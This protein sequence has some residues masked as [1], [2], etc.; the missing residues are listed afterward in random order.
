MRTSKKGIDLIKQFE[1]CKLYAYRDAVGKPTIGYGH[2]LGVKMGTTITQAQADKFLF[3]DIEPIEKFLD[4]LGLALPQNKYDALVSWIFNLGTGNFSTS[5]M[6]KYIIARRKD[7]EI[8]DQMVKW[9]YANRVPLLG[10]MRRR[11]A[12]ANMWLN[13]DVYYVDKSTYTIK[14][15]TAR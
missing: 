1:G 2:T 5:T 12:E 7:E 10:L 13:A 15:R 14:K 4:R 3:S 6:R 8:T 9:H 11:C